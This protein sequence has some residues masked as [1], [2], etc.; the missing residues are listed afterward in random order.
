M[1]IQNRINSLKLVF[2]VRVHEIL[3]SFELN[4]D[5]NYIAYLTIII[6]PTFTTKYEVPYFNYFTLH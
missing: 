6:H 4:L 3:A 5:T 2:L 1:I